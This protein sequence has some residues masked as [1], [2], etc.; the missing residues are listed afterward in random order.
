M[1]EC[2]LNTHSLE[3]RHR[4]RRTKKLHKVLFYN[5]LKEGTQPAKSATT[6]LCKV[7]YF[8]QVMDQSNVTKTLS[9]LTKYSSK[10]T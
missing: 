4:A 10:W 9:L 7:G 3:I 2:P 8:L 6:L 5:L 1:L